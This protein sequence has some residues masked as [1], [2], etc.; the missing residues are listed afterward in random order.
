MRSFLA[1]L[2]L[3]LMLL[4]LINVVPMF[5]LTAHTNRQWREYRDVEEMQEVVAL[6]RLVAERE[7]RLVAGRPEGPLVTLG[8]PGRLRS[9]LTEVEAPRGTSIT[10]LDDRGAILAREPDASR[11]VGQSAV[12]STLFRDIIARHDHGTIEGKDLDGEPKQIAHRIL[13]GLARPVH[14]VVAVPPASVVEE[15]NEIVREG[16]ILE[17]A[18]ATLGLALAWIGAS[19]FILRPARTLVHATRRLAAGDLGA[20]TGLVRGS[21]ELHE[22]SR[23][24]DDMATVLETRH[25]EAE[26]AREAL[27]AGREQLEERVRSRTA[28]L[29]SANEALKKLSSAVMQAADSIIITDRDGIIEY[30]NPAFER[31][32][33]Y[34]ATEALGRTPRI[35]KSGA[36]DTAF[37]EDLWRQISA[38]AVFHGVLVNRTKAGT[39][40]HEE[41][42][43]TPIRDEHGTI[44]HYVSAGRDITDRKQAEEELEKSRAALRVLAAHLTSVREEERSRIARDV[45]D[46]LGQLLAVLK[47]ELR[48]LDEGPVDG[49]QLTRHVTEMTELIDRMMVSVH[50]IQ[51]EL[52][53]PVLDVL[54]LVAAID[55]QAR[56][57]E[58]QSGIPCR[59]VTNTEHLRVASDT[60]TAIFRIVQEALANVSRH[61]NA[62]AVEIRLQRY[63]DSLAVT[64]R[65]DGRGIAETELDERHSIGIA[66]MRERAR[67]LG[68]RLT[69]TGRPGAGTTVMLEVPLSTGS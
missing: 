62:H 45:H 37:Y 14:L 30:V 25:H 29:V 66:G 34:A 54:G 23:A 67:L 64:V 16:L 12:A 48:R 50:R 20:R 69:L 61:A 27:A 44:T 51:T 53:P 11:W 15:E 7:E 28:D 46:D 2:R 60:S 36:H 68:G 10:L 9:V 39:L 5:I 52:R 6:A 33:G 59:F 4:V 18:V 55:W 31:L 57:F 1:S 40:Y 13:R 65:D 26:R 63:P 8:D 35:V 22:L 38:G 17:I 21:G 19:L 49:A 47:L 32:T 24:F 41:K 58:A 42:T 43:I 3:R 56:Q